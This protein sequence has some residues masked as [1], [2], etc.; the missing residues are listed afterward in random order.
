MI[1][2]SFNATIR[3][4]DNVEAVQ[5]KPY[6]VYHPS[7][8]PLRHTEQRQVWSC[9]EMT[10]MYQGRSW[11]VMM[12]LAEGEAPAAISVLTSR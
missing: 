1:D 11:W 4:K 9:G 5:K 10:D 12:K 7:L 2:R 3:L 8:P 6:P